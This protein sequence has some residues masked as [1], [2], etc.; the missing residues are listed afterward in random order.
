[1]SSIDILKAETSVLIVGDHTR[2]DKTPAVLESEGLRTVHCRTGEETL[3]S[4]SNHRTD[5]VILD[6]SLSDMD[7]LLVME[8]LKAL[9]PR[10]K[11][12]VCAEQASVESAMAAINKGAFAF[13]KKDRSDE[14]FLFHINR[15]TLVGSNEMLEEKVGKR[16]EELL[17]IN[18]ELEREIEERRLTEEALLESKMFLDNTINGIGDRVFVKDKGHRWVV[19]NDAL[20]KRLGQSREEL[21]GKEEQLNL[22]NISHELRTP[23]HAILNFSK[24][25]TKKIDKVPKEKLL[26]YFAQTNLAGTRLMTLLNDLLDLSKLEAGKMDY[27]MEEGDVRQIVD[28]VVS[29]LSTLIK[30]NGQMLKVIEPEFSTRAVCDGYKIGQVVRNLLSNSTKFTPP[31]KNITISFDQDTIETEYGTSP[32]LRVSVADQGIGIPENELDAVFDKFVQSS[33]TKTGAGGTGL[34]LSICYEIVKA[35]QGKIW[36]E[37]N[38]DDGAVFRFLLPYRLVST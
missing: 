16:N 30:E 35:H 27:Q 13:L 22:A 28:T 7:G 29:E 25:G 20:C 10:V 36:T 11:I 2:H 19:L 8:K 18:R 21:V 23:M 24:F 34:G 15:A 6:P 12:V 17:R 3:R 32:A 1:M 9:N 14:E 31:G 5:I 26:H 37:N 4:F 33:K 38:P